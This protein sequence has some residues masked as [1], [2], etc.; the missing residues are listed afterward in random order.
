VLSV[1]AHVGQAPERR[2]LERQV[3]RFNDAASAIEVRINFIPEQSYNAQVQAAAIAGE[4]PDLLE[5]DG[6][7]LYNYV[8][9]GHLVPLD[10]LL[11]AATRDELLPSIEKQ[12]RF[13]GRMYGAGTFDSG[14]GLYASRRHLEDVGA[15]IPSG[16]EEAWTDT[17]FGDLLAALAGRDAD[18]RVLDLKL[19]YSGEWFTYAFSPLLQSAGG[20]LIERGTYRSSLGVLNGS[21]SVRAMTTLQRWLA[22]GYVDRNVDDDAF[23]GGR[24][25]LSW[26]GHWEYPRYSAA[27]GDDLVLLPLPDLGQGSD[28]AL[29]G[30]AGSRALPRVSAAAR[31]S[32]RHGIV[33]RRGAGNP[34]RNR[35]VGVVRAGGAA[36]PVCAPVAGRLFR[37][38]AADAGLPGN[39]LRLSAGIRRHPRRRRRAGRAR[40]CG[41]GH[42]PGYPRQ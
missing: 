18:G 6:P 42:R 3:A 17:E 35:A 32:S 37:P 16:P 4:L 2:V 14:L 22:G 21:E 20:D 9:Q 26:A 12:G 1:W 13:R 31:G 23:V 39:H 40:P 5:F 41:G 27:L 38:A 7:F 30:S 11:S 24:V 34:D 36:E 29:R 8:W 10:G 28:H 15:R 33:Q 19:N 25:A